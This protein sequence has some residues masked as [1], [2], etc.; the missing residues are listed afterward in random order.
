MGKHID[1]LGSYQDFRA[2]W[3]TESGE[4]VEPDRG[5]LKKLLFNARSAKAA[6][7]DERDEA[8]EKLDQAVTDLEAAKKEAASANGEEAQ[9]K[10]TTLEKKVADLTSERDKLVADKEEA[11]LRAEVLGDLDPKMAKYVKGKTREELEKSLEEVKADFGVVDGEGD[12]EDEDRPGL[13]TR[14]RSLLNPGDPEPDKGKGSQGPDPEQVADQ[15]L[16]GGRI[17]G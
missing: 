5:K 4:E 15:I 16:S 17:F 11:E 9:K 3:E 12:E 10:I 13:R 14:P 8:Q 6:A 1:E 7:L 2:P